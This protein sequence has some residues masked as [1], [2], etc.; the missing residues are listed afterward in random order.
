MTVGDIYLLLIQ[1]GFGQC[2]PYTQSL[3]L[4]L[5]DF[6]N[7]GKYD[8]QNSTAFPEMRKMKANPTDKARHNLI[9]LCN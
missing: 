6:G 7:G 9:L 8:S 1:A 4:K 5:S 3:V 2:P